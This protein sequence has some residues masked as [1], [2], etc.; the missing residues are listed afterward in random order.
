MSRAAPARLA[1]LAAAI[2]GSLCAAGAAAAADT[3]TAQAPAEAP[4]AAWTGVERVVAFADVHGAYP[5]LVALL[6]AVGVVDGRLRWSAGKAHVVSTGD[7]LDRGADSRKVMD[8]LMRL[9]GDAVKAGGRLH[10]VLGNHEAMNVLGDLRYVVAGEF[11]AFI[12]DEDPAERA[13]QKDALLARTPGLTAAE[14]ERRFPPGYFGHRR[15]FGPGGRYGRWLLDQPVAIRVND[16]V[17]MHGGPS[18]LL[19]LRSLEQLNRDYRAA[20]ASYAAAESALAEVGLLNFEDAYAGRPELARSRLDS[21]PAAKDQAHLAPL[22]ERFRRAAEDP[23]LGPTGPNWY[24]GAALCNECAEADVLEP[25][26]AQVGARR[27]VVGHTPAR[28]GTVVARFGGALVKLDAGMNHAVYGGRPAALVSE[29]AGSRV[30]YAWS[31]TPPAAPPTEIPAEPLY[32]SSPG[33]GEDGVADVLERG[34]IEVTAT[35]APG[36]LAVRVS[37]GD[38]SVEGVF[39][40]ADRTTV[41]HEIAAYRLDRLLRLGLVPATVARNHGG[42]D[43]VLQG[44]P[45]SWA[46]EQDR[47]NARNGKRTGLACQTISN[48]SRAS[49]ARRALPAD[50]S[51][52]KLPTGGHCDLDAQYQLAYAFDALIGNRVRN[53]DRFLY[54]TDA[55]TLFLSGHFAAFGRSTD[56]PRALEAPLART[57]PELL[58]R[59]RQLDSARLRAALG[60]LVSQRDIEALLKRRD[61]ILELAR[62]AGWQ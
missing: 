8:L 39:E 15:L 11:A 12:A 36:V 59:L 50:G 38:R 17:Y 4:R 42:K 48:G 14:F 20:V 58:D 60:E 61:R 30:V 49:A 27:M 56:V 54:D 19:R 24:R 6:Q 62:P 51:A 41:Q 47:M 29:A 7:L 13:R 46:S 2:A 34:S 26:L 53:P 45:A 28:N 16:T 18:P 43:G 44:R 9:Q 1:L 33:I 10:V 37:H 55:T 40:A 21:R 23:L 22:V 3:A 52:P 35:C 32:L 57:G 31:M 25:F 5:E